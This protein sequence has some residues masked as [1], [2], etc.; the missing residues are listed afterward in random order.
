MLKT[1][2]N[3]AIREH[4]PQPALCSRIFF[5]S[6]FLSLLILNAWED[7]AHVS[8]VRLGVRLTSYRMCLLFAPSYS[9]IMGGCSPR[10]SC[11]VIP[12]WHAIWPADADSRQQ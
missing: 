8:I 10:V 12:Y 1:E 5:L 2:I 6:L 9:S 7:E 11:A 4:M 3:T